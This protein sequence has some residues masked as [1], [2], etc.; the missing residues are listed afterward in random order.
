MAYYDLTRSQ[1]QFLIVIAQ[2]LAEKGEVG[3]IRVTEEVSGSGEV[4][5]PTWIESK[6][7]GHSLSITDIHHLVEEGFLIQKSQDGSGFI[8]SWEV[9]EGRIID[10]VTNDFK[11]PD[12]ENT[13]QNQTVNVTNYGNMGNLTVAQ[14]KEQINQAISSSSKIQAGDK[15]TLNELVDALFKELETVRQKD[16]KLAAS[17]QKAT[18][19][20]A[21][22]LSE[23]KPNREDV[24]ESMGRLERAAKDV[25][26]SMEYVLKTAEAILFFVPQLLRRLL[27]GQDA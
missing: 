11:K 10:A 16:P 25:F 1:K 27:P 5:L 15:V 12:G 3:R 9:F 19:R 2:E 18:Q 23:D 4:F 7:R 8:T 17:V 26:N 22:D 21:E 13:G 24:E 6:L 20:L 14:S